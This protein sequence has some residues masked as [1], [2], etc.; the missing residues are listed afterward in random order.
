MENNQTRTKPNNYL[1]LAIISTVFCCLI[2]GI[3]SIVNAA[4]VNEAYALGNY[5][6]A[7]RA[8]KNAK[9]WAIVGIAIAGLFWLIYIAFFGLALFGG[10][11]SG[12][13]F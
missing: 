1:V 10:L 8:S 5:E 12:G 13:D 11:M 9:T 4:K 6:Q 7:E 3:V 2:P